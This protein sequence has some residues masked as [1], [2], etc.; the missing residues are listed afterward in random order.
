MIELSF[1]HTLHKFYD[2]RKEM[3]I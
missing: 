3:R 2:L 1:L